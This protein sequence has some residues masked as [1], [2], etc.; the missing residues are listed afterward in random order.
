MVVPLRDAPSTTTVFSGT[1]IF[2][3]LSAKIPSFFNFSRSGNGHSQYGSVMAHRAWSLN[4]F[5]IGA[6][7]TVLG[8]SLPV[9]VGETS[10]G[11]SITGQLY[12][13]DDSVAEREYRSPEDGTPPRRSGGA[14]SDGDRAPDAIRSDATSA[15]SPNSTQQTQTPRSLPARES[16]PDR[17]DEDREPHGEKIYRAL[18]RY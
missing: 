18:E 13:Q 7:I 8:I 14:V 11:E 1:G 10:A 15:I 17:M 5:Q 2:G 12:R 6:R 4:R 9:T 16:G 3:T